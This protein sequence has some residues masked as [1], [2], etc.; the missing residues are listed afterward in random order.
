MKFESL[1]SAKFEKLKSCEIKNAHYVVGGLSTCTN[2]AGDVLMPGQ[3]SYDTY[4]S[5]TNKSTKGDSDCQ[6]P[7]RITDINAPML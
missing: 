7:S 2:N 1:N 5:G 3:K 6:T 4:D